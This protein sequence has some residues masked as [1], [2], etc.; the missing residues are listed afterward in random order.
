VAQDYRHAHSRSRF[1]DSGI[2]VSAIPLLLLTRPQE[3]PR[4]WD[5]CCSVHNKF[6]FDQFVQVFCLNGVKNITVARITLTAGLLWFKMERR[7]TLSGH[8][9]SLSLI[10]LG[11]CH[12]GKYYIDG[13]CLGKHSP[14]QFIYFSLLKEIIKRGI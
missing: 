10:P 4:R 11:T 1:T 12:S 9:P 6:K 2:K 5:V 8:V 14:Y 13:E 7:M 3:S